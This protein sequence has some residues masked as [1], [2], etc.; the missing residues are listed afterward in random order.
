MFENFKKIKIKG[1]YFDEETELE[2]FKGDVPLSVVYGRNGSGKSTIARCLKQLSESEEERIEREE[3]VAR[4]EETDYIVNSE[5]PIADEHK[6]SIFVFDEDFLRN[7][8][9]VENDGL[10]AIVMLGEQVELDEKINAKNEEL[11]RKTEE[12]NQQEE[13][14]KR[15]S[16]IEENISPRYYWNQIR[17]GLRENGGWADIDRDLK[18]NTLKSRITD[19]LVNI[20]MKMEE[21]AE[22]Y[23]QLRERVKADMRLYLGAEDSQVIEWAI[24]KL[25]LPESLEDLTVLLE[26]PLDSP[27]LTEREQRLMELLTKI[28]QEPQHFEQFHTLHMLEEGWTFCPLCLREITEKDRSSI[29]EVLTHLLNKEA[30]EFNA[31][32]NIAYDLFAEIKIDMPKFPDNLN[33]TELDAAV[34]TKEEL[35]KVLA[36]LREKI[37]QRKRNIYKPLKTP[38]T[39]KMDEA[40]SNVRTA[41]KT[42]LERVLKCV[43][44]FNETVNKRSKLFERV[45]HENNML[46]RKQL[47][48][49]LM[50]YKMALTNEDK[51]KRKLQVLKEQKNELIA[52]IKELKMQKERTDIALEYINKE[53]QYVFYSNRKVKLIPGEGCYK[54]TVNGKEVKPKKISVGERNVLGL[55]YFFAMLFSGKRNEDKYTSEYLIVIDD[56]ISSFDYGNRLGV[57]SLLR[58]QFS[59]IKKGNAN[60]R[61]LV[62]SHDLQ[63]VFDLVKIRSDLQGGRGEKKFLE[64]ENRKIKEQSV[65]NE[66]QKLLTHVYEYASC[67]RPEDLDEISE[68]GIGNIMRRMLEAFS[69]FCYNKPFETM[70]R[71]EGVISNIPE[72]KRVYYENFMCRLTLNGESH[73]EERVYTLSNFTP[74]FTKEEKLQTAKSV[75]LFLL[76]VN[77]PHIKAYLKPEVVARIESWKREENG[78]ISTES[79]I[80]ESERAS[81]LELES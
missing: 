6:S 39:D 67:D 57:M 37:E 22:T 15:Y 8:V 63:S 38:F 21:P 78:W 49:A 13:L 14:V 54:L 41:W 72:D 73:E 55:C 47:A 23:E 61:L 30:K 25:M 7:N 52:A 35:N 32:L 45:R 31:N 18:G 79:T 76:Y 2:F 5:A 34:A 59:N 26:S 16:N 81:S 24:D 62:M 1:G 68:M 20:L 75:L 71:T 70:M 28:S 17:E 36:T 33:K 74:F 10:N 46:A 60:S 58:Y 44:T 29:A 12:F 27:Q 80:G 4:G 53:L 77:E 19:D 11:S 50:G 48:S 51:D 43:E 40:Y 42:V 9:R 65:R 56:P 66:Y 3:N 69:S 64:L